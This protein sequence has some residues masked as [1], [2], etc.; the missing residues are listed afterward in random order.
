[1]RA[2]FNVWFERYVAR[3][4]PVIA[5]TEQTVGGTALQLS[6]PASYASSTARDKW[7][8]LQSDCDL[9]LMKATGGISLSSSAS[10]CDCPPLPTPA[11]LAGTPTPHPAADHW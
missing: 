5:S 7:Q 4:G 11:R 2:S 9:C 10:T 1:M 8:K 3:D 6:H